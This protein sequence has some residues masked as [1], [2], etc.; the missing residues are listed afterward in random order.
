M[1][2]GDLR[3]RGPNGRSGARNADRCR[4]LCRSAEELADRAEEMGS[5]R[6]GRRKGRSGG[7]NGRWERKWPDR[8]V[9]NVQG[10][11]VCKWQIGA[12]KGMAGRA[13]GEDAISLPD[14]PI[15]SAGDAFATPA[16]RPSFRA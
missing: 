10:R 9:K 5:G 2:T 4:G 12:E 8:A 1:R 13:A 3:A 14:L 15:S 16:V 11:A 6:S 7:G